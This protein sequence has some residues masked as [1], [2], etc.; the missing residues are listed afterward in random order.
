MEWSAFPPQIF[1]FI[2]L[3]FIVAFSSS[4][5]VAAIE[6]E[7]GL[8]LDYNRELETV[9]ISNLL[10]GCTGGFTG[11]YIFSQTIFSMRRGV[12][13]RVNGFVIVALQILVILVPVPVT[14]YIPKAFFG[15]L[16]VLIA[17][18]LMTEWLLL[19]RGKMADP[20]YLVCLATFCAIL[21]TGV[22]VGMLIGILC[23]MVCFVVMYARMPSV[24]ATSL[25]QSS[26]VRTFKEQV[27]LG[28]SRGK[29]M[30]IDLSGYIFFGSAVQ[31]LEDLKKRVRIRVQEN[32]SEGIE[33][34]ENRGRKEEEEE[35]EEGEE[36][37]GEGEGEEKEDHVES[38]KGGATLDTRDV[39]SVAAY[40]SE[41]LEAQL[42][43]A[44]TRNDTAAIGDSSR[45]PRKGA[46]GGS[47]STSPSKAPSSIDL[48]SVYD[49]SESALR[50]HQERVISSQTRS[51]RP[52]GGPVTPRSSGMTTRSGVLAAGAH[53]TAREKGKSS[54]TDGVA[55]HGS[56]SSWFFNVYAD[57]AADDA[58]ASTSSPDRQR[59]RSRSVD[60]ES[61]PPGDRRLPSSAGSSETRANASVWAHWRPSLKKSAA[62]LSSTS[63]PSTSSKSLAGAAVSDAL[64]GDRETTDRAFSYGS[65]GDFDWGGRGGVSSDGRRHGATAVG[66]SDVVNTEYLVLN[67]ETVHGVDAT[68]ARSCFLMLMQLMKR[69]GVLVVFAAMR[70][71]VERIFRAQQVLT[72][73]DIVLP[74]CDDALE[75]CEELTLARQEQAGKGNTRH[76][77]MSGGESG[78]GGGGHTG[79]G[80]AGR[81]SS[82]YKA[83]RL[84]RHKH[85]LDVLSAPQD[86]SPTRQGTASSGRSPFPK[87]ARKRAMSPQHVSA[88]Q[89]SLPMPIPLSYDAP[90]S[91]SSDVGGVSFGVVR[92]RGLVKILEDY[93]EI[94]SSRRNTNTS[95]TEL[96]LSRELDESVLAAYFEKQYVDSHEVLYNPHSLP[97][98]VF[99]IESGVVELLVTDDARDGKEDLL[100]KPVTRLSKV[101][102]GGIF[103]ID[104]FLL[105]LPH[106]CRALTVTECHIWRIDR[107]S[108]AKMEVRHPK[109]CLIIQQ[110]LLKSMALLSN[111]TVYNHHGLLEGEYHPIYQDD[112]VNHGGDDDDDDDTRGGKKVILGA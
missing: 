5:D 70:P 89:A 80:R 86:P 8:P 78:G 77:G 111:A 106:R 18:D 105:N 2:G 40:T 46:R 36:E 62:S 90:G 60:D 6:M 79:P 13:S 85:A 44:K 28:T 92:T 91:G 71:S 82:Y 107:S 45:T 4:L 10:S 12:S 9:G 73:E 48:V 52:A 67:F 31:I 32:G 38:W 27:A 94:R 63:S 81:R 41:D 98:S 53:A 26:V 39:R 11:S 68:A 1:K 25:K 100:S 3:F 66:V 37:E 49:I 22:E 54:E 55:E 83:A 7:L 20:E 93:M 101:S 109:L 59:L 99:F 75:L 110:V 96:A 102:S 19:A 50:R 23:A 56:N 61:L 95:D 33:T 42:I 35:G 87:N 16:L 15:S 72:E 43:T 97:N 64:L 103:G 74:H 29:I 104:A 24:A 47:A 69:S 112:D 17:A 76:G 84:L 57:D 108:L 30:T 65:A 51:E 21:F 34:C 88:A 58:E 14:S